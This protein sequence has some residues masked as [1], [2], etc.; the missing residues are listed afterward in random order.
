MS[1]E[2]KIIEKNPIKSAIKNKKGIIICIVAFI[3]ILLFGPDLIKT[4]STEKGDDNV[5]YFAEVACQFKDC[6]KLDDEILVSFTREEEEE[7]V[8]CALIAINNKG[9]SGNLT[10][11]LEPGT[12]YAINGLYHGYKEF[13]I[14]DASEEY[15]LEIDCND[16]TMEL[17]EYDF[18]RI[19]C[20]HANYEDFELE[21]TVYIQSEK[22]D[23]LDTLGADREYQD[24][25]G[26]LLAGKYT[27][28]NTVSNKT[29]DL[30]VKEGEEYTLDVDWKDGSMKL[31]KGKYSVERT[32]QK[33]NYIMEDRRMPVTGC[34]GKK[35]LMISWI[36]WESNICERTM[37]RPLI[38]KPATRLMQC[39]RS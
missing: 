12:Y 38:W 24:D 29:I 7:N 10:A 18:A 39:S 23:F 32:E 1:D 8:I 5:D 26:V 4:I 22:A 13:E 16:G 6:E 20:N 25:D 9:Q 2:K 37:S 34:L 31:H 30:E 11:H 3:G 35:E 33:W 27:I 19:Y 17:K 15:V 28:S 36:S 21:E 14:K